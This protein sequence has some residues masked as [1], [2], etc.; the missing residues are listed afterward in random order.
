M[1]DNREADLVR[2]VMPVTLL[3]NFSERLTRLC[4]YA[5]KD[6]AAFGRSLVADEV[7]A[8]GGA[9]ARKGSTLSRQKGI[10]T[11]QMRVL[12]RA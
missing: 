5:G 3:A 12:P 6:G 10:G 2:R 11:L 1:Q 4:L 8:G 9:S 7:S